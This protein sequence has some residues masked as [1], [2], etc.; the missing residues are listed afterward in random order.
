MK[1]NLGNISIYIDKKEVSYD[2]IPMPLNWRNFSVDGRFKI[3][4]D[5]S[6]L[7]SSPHEIECKII[8]NN[9][10]I[11]EVESGEDLALISFFKNDDKLSIGTIDELEDI[12]C[13]YLEDGL[14]VVIG[15]NHNSEKIIFGVSW[16]NL[17]NRNPE[18]DTHTWFSSDPSFF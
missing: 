12:E 18:D 9:L 14:K 13:S 7:I 5:I 6:K 2:A 1:T 16:I 17:S 15:E 4:I 3:E 11:G 8:S 10:N